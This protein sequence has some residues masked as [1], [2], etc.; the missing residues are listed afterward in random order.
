M[1]IVGFPKLFPV[2]LAK[3]TKPPGSDKNTKKTVSP[4]KP[5]KPT[6]PT[7]K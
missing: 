1:K 5:T 6:K 7:K 2:V 3:N 4:A